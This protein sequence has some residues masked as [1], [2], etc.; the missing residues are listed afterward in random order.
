MVCLQLVS[1]HREQL[2]SRNKSGLN[3]NGNARTRFTC[4]MGRVTRLAATLAGKRCGK[5]SAAIMI[6]LRK[7]EHNSCTTT[8][9]A[10]CGA[11]LGLGDRALMV[12]PARP[13]LSP[14]R[15]AWLARRWAAPPQRDCSAPA[16]ARQCFFLICLRTIFRYFIIHTLCAA[17]IMPRCDASSSC[18][19]SSATAFAAACRAGRNS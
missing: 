15:G 7:Y 16:A 10:S 11:I 5:S 8:A 6:V 4:G 1:E 18:R 9:L 13:Q 12:E 14:C 17:Q 19:S 2:Y 3:I